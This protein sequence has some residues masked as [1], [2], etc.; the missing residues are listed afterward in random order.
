MKV[1]I[2]FNEKDPNPENIGYKQVLWEILIEAPDKK[3]EI[4]HDWGYAFWNGTSW[5]GMEDLP[6]G[7]TAVV[8]RWADPL[9]PA[10]LLEEPKRII[11]I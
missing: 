8:C 11:K 4:K 1:T 6:T 5:D 2:E 10:V 7:F 9:N 3:P